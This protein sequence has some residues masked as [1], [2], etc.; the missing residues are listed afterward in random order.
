MALSETALATAAVL[1][2]R[3]VMSNMANG[4]SEEVGAKFVNFLQSKLQIKLGAQQV[5][6]EHKQLESA[7]LNRARVDR[8]FKNELEQLVSEFQKSVNSDPNYEQSHID[9]NQQNISG[10]AIGINNNVGSQ[11]FR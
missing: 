11:F 9:I 8:E 7:I 5:K 2:I 3:S 4:A 10:P 6:Q 1:I